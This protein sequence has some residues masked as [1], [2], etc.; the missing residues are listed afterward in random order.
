MYLDFWKWILNIGHRDS[1]FL[2][3]SWGSVSAEMSNNNNVYR[4]PNKRVIENMSNVYKPSLIFCSSSSNVGSISSHPSGGAFRLL[5]TLGIT[6]KPNF[7]TQWQTPT[8]YV[9]LLER[10]CTNFFAHNTQLFVHLFLL[11]N[12]RWQNY[13]YV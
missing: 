11:T 4:R 3:P 1:C 7:W 5:L 12:F 2:L 6:N 8:G 10:R 9:Q 13:V